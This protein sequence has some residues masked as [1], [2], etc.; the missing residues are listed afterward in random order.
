MFFIELFNHLISNVGVYKSRIIM[1]IIRC[2]YPNH[3]IQLVLS[4][5]VHCSAFVINQDGAFATA[6]AHGHT[7]IV[8]LL[9]DKGADPNEVE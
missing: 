3:A 6:A 1:V 2:L 9:L 5:C 8:K 7:D 4:S